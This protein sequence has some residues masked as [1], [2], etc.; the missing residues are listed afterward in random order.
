MGFGGHWFLSL[1][2]VLE[3]RQV[4]L[5]TFYFG[6]WLQRGSTLNVRAQNSSNITR[7]RVRNIETRKQSRRSVQC[8]NRHYATI[9]KH[10]RF[11]SSTAGLNYFFFQISI[12]TIILQLEVH[13]V[14]CTLYLMSNHHEHPRFS[15]RCH[16]LA[17][18]HQI[19]I[20]ERVGYILYMSS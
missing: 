13:S 7:E 2:Y 11:V 8:K 3:T 9:D 10:N 18:C 15:T 14:Q 17:T 20:D 4:P 12:F 16:Q 5:S 1:L 6:C 19:F